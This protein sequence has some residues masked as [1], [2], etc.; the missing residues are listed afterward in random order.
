MK[1]FAGKALGIG[2]VGAIVG[3][4]GY[5]L[6]YGMPK[7]YHKV[8]KKLKRAADDLSDLVSSVGDSIRHL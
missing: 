1:T 2:A 5:M 8:E 7:S 3:L 6:I 4:H